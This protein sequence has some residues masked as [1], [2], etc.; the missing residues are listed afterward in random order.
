MHTK[1]LIGFLSQNIKCLTAV[2]LIG[3]Q[4]SLAFALLVEGFSVSYPD[5]ILAEEHSSKTRSFKKPR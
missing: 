4:E 3:L 5:K 1:L 2:K